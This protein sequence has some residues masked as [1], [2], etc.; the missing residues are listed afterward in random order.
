MRPGVTSI[1]VFGHFSDETNM[2]TTLLEPS[3]LE[4]ALKIRDLTDPAQGF[5]A[6]QILIDDIV[7][8][9]S[10]IWSCPA[11]IR[12]GT[13]IVDVT[14]NY[15]VLRYPPDDITRA[16]RYT[17]YVEETRVLRTHTTAMIPPLL[18]QMA[19]YWAP[20]DVLLA[21]PG[22]TYRRDVI[23][24]LH[25]G[26]P[27][28]LDLW[29]VHRGPQALGRGNL[30]AM[31][32][33]VVAAAL[34][35]RTYRIRETEHCY[36]LNGLEINVAC[37]NGEWIEIGECGL[38]HP[39]VLGACGLC[40]SE[41]SGLAMGLGLDRL[42][43][44]RKGIDDVR[45]LRST[46]PRVVRQMGDLQPYRT[47]S[48]MPSI[49]RDMSIVVDRATTAEELGDRIRSSLGEDARAIEEIVVVKEDP[50]SELPAA[51]TSRL[52]MSRTQKNVLLRVV[53]SDLERT[54]THE[55]ANRL[56]NA[57][58]GAVHQGT[59]VEWAKDRR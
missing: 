26:E 46:D 21:C 15:D 8:T 22:I 37:G 10:E 54:L 39:E 58:Y 14:D 34:P 41:T 44:L 3:A 19:S 40:P 13:P 48:R 35:D 51:V 33:A 11:W 31:V 57:I 5:S 23:D 59:T 27:H 36:T 24:R 56:R 42:L 38:A 52:G 45:L 28:Q 32:D 6:I 12:R 1:V 17:R 4:R 55:E 25:T 29:R 50:Y 7:R 53:I 18:R 20:A 47:V 16:S 30:L 2:A 43:M 9:L 49:R